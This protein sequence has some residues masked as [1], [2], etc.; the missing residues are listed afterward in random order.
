MWVR[1]RAFKVSN[2]LSIACK[3]Y[4]CKGSLSICFKL[5]WP[6]PTI[7]CLAIIYLIETGIFLNVGL[8][9]IKW[10][11]GYSLG[12]LCDFSSIPHSFHSSMLRLFAINP[13]D[14]KVS[15][16]PSPHWLIFGLRGP[17]RI[18]LSPEMRFQKGRKV[19]WSKKNGPFFSHLPH[20]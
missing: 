10:V 2:Y 8:L 17:L 3:L 20:K 4:T 12:N 18:I 6:P 14:T 5:V 19:D 16:T 1:V 15:A 13:F 7:G 11:L 9:N